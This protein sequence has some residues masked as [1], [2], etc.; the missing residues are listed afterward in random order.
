MNNDSTNSI[1]SGNHSVRRTILIVI[2]IILGLGTLAVV[3]AFL[4]NLFSQPQQY[5]YIIEVEEA[6][7]TFTSAEQAE[8]GPY[9]ATV[10]NIVQQE[11][12][13]TNITTQFRSSEGDNQNAPTTANER[14]AQITQDTQQ[15]TFVRVTMQYTYDS[16]LLE[17][18]DAAVL[19][20]W[21]ESIFTRMQLNGA[22]PSSVT[23]GY[24]SS[25]ETMEKASEEGGLTVNY[26]FPVAST[27]TGYVITYDVVLVTGSS[28]VGNN[29]T[30]NSYRYTINF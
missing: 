7:K 21:S 2:T 22:Q 11:G 29:E 4:F 28:T 17:D 10:V 12:T 13:P 5:A 20:A 27:S 14:Q 9:K 30:T 24:V 25:T 1:G 16:S 23:P 6:N 26:I 15:S 18:Q 8:I 19:D 3:G